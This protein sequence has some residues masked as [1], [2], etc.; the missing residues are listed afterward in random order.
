MLEPVETCGALLGGALISTLD[1]GITHGVGVEVVRPDNTIVISSAMLQAEERDGPILAYRN[2]VEPMTVQSVGSHRVISRPV[3]VLDERFLPLLVCPDRAPNAQLNIFIL[4]FE[5]EQAVKA[6]DRVLLPGIP[7]SVL[8]VALVA[9]L[10]TTTALRPVERMRAQA[11]QISATS[12]DQRLVV[13]KSRDHLARLAQTFNDSLTRLATSARRQQQFIADAAHE[14]RSPISTL[15]VLLETGSAAPPSTQSAIIADAAVEARRLQRL[16]EDL[17]LLSKL[18]GAQPNAFEPV[19]L[20]E[21]VRRQLADRG[22]VGPVRFAA[23]VDGSAVVLGNAGHLDRLLSNLLDN[24]EQHAQST[25]IAVLRPADDEIRLEVIDDGP[26]IPAE[27]RE[28]V[29]E[30]FTRLDESRA[31]VDGGAGLGLAIARDICVRHHGWLSV[32]DA[33]GG[34]ARFTACFPAVP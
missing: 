26:G 32:T 9:W 19:D 6:V 3:T 28:K 5:A 27:Y 33:E 1:K 21:L 14:L 7:L 34:G 15:R 17:L 12:L 13:P 30:R 18:D 11:A 10:A 8:L 25:V 24:A 4:P 22:R 2:D 16:A 20:S 31:R 23:S 29:F